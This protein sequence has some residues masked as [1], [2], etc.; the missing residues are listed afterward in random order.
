MALKQMVVHSTYT[1]AR[2]AR[3]TAT[4][5]VV[6]VAGISGGYSSF[7]PALSA[8]SSPSLGVRNAH[9]MVYA[10]DRRSVILFGGANA[11]KVCDDTWEWVTDARIWR[12]INA[13]GPAP[14]T[15]PAF[16]YDERRQ[17]AVLFGGNR[18]LF[19]RGDEENTFLADTWLFTRGRWEHRAVAGPTPRAEPGIAYDRDRGRVVLFGGYRR[20]SGGTLRLGDTW[21]WDG[22]HWVNVAVPGPTPRNGSAM[23]YDERR[24][25]VVLFGGP[26]P[27]NETWEWDGVRWTP[28]PSGTEAGRFN[29]AMI[30]DAAR[31]LIVRFGGW[32]GAARV[33]DTWTFDGMRWTLSQAIG[34]PARNHAA[35]AYDRRRER[36]VLF[37]GHDGDNVFGDTWE[38]DGSEWQRVAFTASQK[39]VDNGH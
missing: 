4:L 3:A 36:A 12:H 10:T 27:S 34:P 24:R 2:A 26:G 13:R 14:R 11:S 18:V 25:R 30:Y 39:R 33:G 1:F 8:K 17:A 38:W 16:A 20:S 28:L 6:I 32:T 23:A 22:Q 21:E 9:A 7:T 5:V 35:F 19:G 31:A 15:F 37:G 29:P